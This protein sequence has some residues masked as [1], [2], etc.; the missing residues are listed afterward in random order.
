[1]ETRKCS[2]CKMIKSMKEF[3]RTA[4]YCRSCFRQYHKRWTTAAIFDVPNLTDTDKRDYQ[5]NKD[6]VDRQLEEFKRRTE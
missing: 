6:R 4:K 1:M 5:R 3:A 2:C